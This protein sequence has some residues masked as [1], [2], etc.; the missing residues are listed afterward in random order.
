MQI[1][2]ELVHIVNKNK[3]RSIEVIGNSRENKSMVMDFYN[4]IAEERLTS[5]E[6]AAQHFYGTDANNHSYKKLKNRLKN[7]LINT[8]FFIDVKQPSYNQRQRAYYECY[9]DW[10]AVKILTGKHARLS[11]VSISHKILKQAKK[12]EFSELVLDVA[13]FLRLHYGTREGNIKKYEFYNDLF[14][15]Y[16]QTWAKENLSEYLY[17]ELVTRYVNSKATQGEI[18]NKAKEAFAQLEDILGQYESYRLQFCAF[19]IKNLIYVSINDYEN[20]VKV[21]DEAIQVFK[22]KEYIASVPIQIFLHQQLISFTQL[23]QFDRG[24]MVAEE[25]IA[26]LEEGSFNWF[27]HQELYFTLS[28]H[29]GQYQQAYQIFNTAV[30]HRRFQFLHPHLQEMWKIYEGFLHYLV[31]VERIEPDGNDKR[32]R[33]FRAGKF[34]NETPIFS[35]DKRGMNIPILVIQIL[36]MILQKKYDQAIDRIEAIEKYCSRYLRKDDTFRSNCF[37]KMLLQI[38]I[39]G[40]HRAAVVRRSEKYLKRL[41]SK[42]IDIANQASEIEIIPYEEL[43]SF[44]LDSLH[45]EFHKSKRKVSLVGSR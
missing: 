40:F 26:L 2:R 19:L 9:K 43:W 25:C 8:V 14:E 35:K 45:N 31:A 38:P 22:Q 10:A 37:I 27:K 4:C 6:A 15:E 33:R 11:A 1:L 24:K 16:E 41:N 7:R 17:V 30:K 44:A 13:R 12:Y 34:F 36:F 20:T 23:K 42:S 3:V 32:F 29:T 21:C 18:H 28:M 5:D 39:S